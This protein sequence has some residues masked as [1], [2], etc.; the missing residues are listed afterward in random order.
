MFRCIPLLALCGAA[1]A[2]PGS[3]TVARTNSFEVYSDAGPQTVRSTIEWFEELR[4][5]F[6]RQTGLNVSGRAPVRVIVFR[7]GAEYEAYRPNPAAAAFYTGDASRD[8]I[9]M[10]QST[11]NWEGIAAHEYAHS[12]MHANGLLLPPWLSE[13]V[14]EVYSTVHIE[15]RTSWIGGDSRPR[16]QTLAREAWIA[17]RQLLATTEIPKNGVELFYAESWALAHMLAFS[18]EYGPRFTALLKTL[19]S[20]M[21]AEQALS[22]LYSKSVQAVDSDLHA[23]VAGGPFR[24]VAFAGIAHAA[25][26]ET[27][28]V[29]SFEQRRLLADLF[30]VSGAL[31]RAESLYKELQR[32]A[33]GDSDVAIALGE[34]A[35][36]R[37]DKRTAMREWKPAIAKGAHDP[38][39]CYRYAALAQQTGMPDADIIPV[40]QR[41]VALDPAFDDA[42]YSL[43]LM[44]ISAGRY[45]DGVTN[46]KA[47]RTIAPAR[48]YSYWSA[49][50]NAL[51]ELDRREEAKAAAVEA[52]RHAS[53]SEE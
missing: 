50:A 21:S 40:L 8:Y 49:M 9:V 19:S 34:I 30:F 38:K 15:E 44:L 42:R 12:L 11:A 10:T 13:G 36:R 2:A 1:V 3:W 43:A 28:E 47:M 35:L 39:L 7:T 46:L 22:L 14:A 5:F 25:A 33:P 6:L 26:P 48:A 29:S 23:W 45:G 16:S 18:P 4:A 17:L 37:A 51:T 52:R 32:E 53:T 20:G 24:A 31:P 41:A 27:A